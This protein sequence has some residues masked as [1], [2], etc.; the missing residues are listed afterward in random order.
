MNGSRINWR[1]Q[2][3]GLTKAPLRTTIEGAVIKAGS[4]NLAMSLKASN[5]TGSSIANITDLPLRRIL[6][7]CWN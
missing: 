5:N 6:T 1:Y 7:T 3:I 4:S 2:N